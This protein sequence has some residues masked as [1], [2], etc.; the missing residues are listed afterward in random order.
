MK[1]STLLL[2]VVFGLFPTIAL[3]WSVAADERRMLGE[4]VVNSGSERRQQQVIFLLVYGLWAAT[5]AMWNWMRSEHLF[6]IVLWLVVSIVAF[7]LCRIQRKRMR[8]DDM[9]AS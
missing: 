2:N 9:A 4:R 3:A 8:S 5:L 7:V 6:W 1:L